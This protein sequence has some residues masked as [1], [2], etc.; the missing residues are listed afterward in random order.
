MFTVHD[1]L[2]KLLMAGH[3]DLPLRY[4]HSQ[5]WTSLIF[6]SSPLNSF[7]LIFKII[8]MMNKIL[9]KMQQHLRKGIFQCPGAA[10]LAVS[11]DTVI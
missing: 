2:M 5:R 7:P 9:I 8:L 6:F 11:S 10:V 1:K 4:Y 3:I